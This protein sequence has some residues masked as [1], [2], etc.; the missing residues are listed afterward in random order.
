MSERSDSLQPGQ[1]QRLNEVFAAAL[2]VAPEKQGELLQHAC[3]GDERLQ[4]EA[5][6]MLRAARQAD[7][8]GFL[9]SDVFADG[10]RVLV[11]NEIPPGTVIGPYRVVREVGRGGMGA[12]YL[13]RREGFHQQVALKI[14]KRGMDTD[15]IVRRFVLERDVLASLNHPNIARLLDGGTTDG[16]PFIVME[17][18]EGETITEFCDQKR[19]TI[20][21]RL[22]LFRKVCAA[23]VYA[24]QNLVVHRDI[25]P[26]NILIASDGE[27]KL[28]DFGIAKLLSPDAFGDTI[29]ATA[30]GA[31]L[32]TPEYAAPEQIRGERITTASDVYSLGVLLYELLCGHRPFSFKNSQA[33]EVLQIISERQPAAPSTA[34][35]A[36]EEIELSKNGT[37]WIVADTVAELRSDK[38]ARL[39]RKLSGDLDNI[40]LT[41]LRKEPG[42]RYSSVLQFSEDVRRHLEGLPVVARR[43]TLSY[44]ASKFIERNRVATVFATLALAAILAGLSI[45]VWQAVVARQQSTRAEQRSAEI[46][47]LT[48]TL[49]KDLATQV[50]VLPGSDP[51]HENLYKVSIEYLN[52]LAQETNDPA[53]LKQLS[54]GYILLGKQFGYENG[55]PEEVRANLLRGLEIS[56]RLVADS[57][58]DMGA[59]RLL[60][61]NLVEYDF[62]CAKEPAE[63]LNLNQER[64]RL[65]EELVA[66]APNDGDNYA[67]LASSYSTL[68]YLFNLYE[69]PE[70]AANYSWLVQQT[71]AREIQ[72]LD[73]SPATN[74]ERDLLSLAYMNYAQDLKDPQTAEDYYQRA[75]AVAEA[76]VAEHPDYRLGWVRLAAANRETAEVRYDQGDYQTALDHFRT[77]LRVVREGTAKLMDAQLRGAEPV[78]MLRVA[79]TLHRTG[80]IEE[81]LRMMHDAA[82]VNNQ[83]NDFGGSALSIASRNAKFLSST[84]DV[85]A[86]FGQRDKALA[87]YREAER[88]WKKVA[89]SEPQQQ[90]NSEAQIARLCLLQGNL[91]AAIPR[92]QPEARNQ[93]QETV[94]I[95]S[96]LKAANEIALGG[97]KDLREAQQKLQALAS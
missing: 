75:L 49:L 26:S 27:P 55:K 43:A 62:F 38:P 63:K 33:N 93:Y 37:K 18:V 40:V 57:P 87:S 80:H 51:A 61:M 56:R 7:S 53:V 42:R 36:R 30:T 66:A 88:L 15:A 74:H 83:I 8:R 4:R 81:A 29:E 45:A 95:L 79:D 2:E 58:K 22:G 65:W 59:K 14:V 76:L 54:E 34:A 44:R 13:A 25:K 91:Y 97:L 89:A 39:Q 41:A 20:N 31:N 28:L 48:N 10:A 21:E 82:T 19:L 73:K 85:Y 23:V 1:W 71:R 9:R 17:Y 46:R 60:A 12:V 6:A 69:R 35:L 86:V 78:Y 67:E 72:L 96:K 77:C 47:R 32:L 70:E 16:L 3:N 24:H 11:A 5:E 94:E 52:G 84:G 90:V 92:G 50:G 68:V 64:T